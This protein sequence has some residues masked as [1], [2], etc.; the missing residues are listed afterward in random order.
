[1]FVIA[2]QFLKTRKLERDRTTVTD[3][4][5]ACAADGA[6][7]LARKNGRRISMWCDKARGAERGGKV[8]KDAET[9]AAE[10]AQG[11]RSEKK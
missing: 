7:N 4:E 2:K 11:T 6:M 10:R 9:C 5:A 8:K 3:A 1:M